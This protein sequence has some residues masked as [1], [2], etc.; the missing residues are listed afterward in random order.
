MPDKEATLKQG[1]GLI[2]QVYFD[3]IGRVVPGTILIGSIYLTILGPADF[4]I[5]LQDWLGKSSGVAVSA[6]AAL[7]LLASYTL[8]ILL[9]CPWFWLMKWIREE[10]FWYCKKDFVRDYET[11]KHGSL[12]AGS[13][14]TKLKA[15]IHMGETLLVGFALCSFLS[16]LSGRWGWSNDHRQLVSGLFALAVLLAC[17]ARN[18]FIFHIMNS[19]EKNLEF[20]KEDDKRPRRGKSRTNKTKK[21]GRRRPARQNL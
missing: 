4:W 13:R 16:L 1:A 19:I 14:L 2:P 8:A 20:L 9:W 15:Q 3:I 7:I 12:S 21:Q 11:V 10:K 6:L 17:C 18:Y 5:R